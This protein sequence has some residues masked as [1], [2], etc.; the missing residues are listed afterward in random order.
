MIFYIVLNVKLGGGLISGV[1]LAAKSINPN[2]RIFAAEPRGANDAAQSKKAGRIITLP[3]TKSIADG[4]RASL[5]DLT[6][7]TLF[8]I[9]LIVI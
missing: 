3:E 6:W 2:I 1:A 4:L 7:Y 5:G 9:L 8:F